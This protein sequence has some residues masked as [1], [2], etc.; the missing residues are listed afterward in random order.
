MMYPLLITY[1]TKSSPADHIIALYFKVHL[2]Y[3]TL[4][5]H[6]NPMEDNFP[7]V[8]KL[9]D[10][11]KE[12]N[13]LNV[14]NLHILVRARR[15]HEV[16]V[17]EPRSTRGFTIILCQ[18]PISWLAKCH[19]LKMQWHSSKRD[20]NMFSDIYIYTWPLISVDFK[21]T[22]RVKRGNSTQNSHSVWWH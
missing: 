13:V 12:R 3:T 16:R 10:D 20:R 1:F 4:S 19:T 6:I 22:V 8:V 7:L 14:M 15:G 17:L 21:K 9:N 2:V 11:V 18:S 5:K